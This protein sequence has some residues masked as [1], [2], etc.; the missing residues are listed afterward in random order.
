MNKRV[1][2]VDDDVSTCQLMAEVLAEFGVE[3]IAASTDEDGYRRYLELGPDLIFIDVLLPRKGGIDLLRRIRS[4]RGGRDVPVFVM[5]AVYRGGDIRAQSV[6]ELGALEFLKKPFQ[7]GTLRQRL[8]E[9]LGGGEEEQ[10]VLEPFPPVENLS[11]GNLGVVELP[12]LLKDLALHETSGCLKLRAGKVKKI[13]YLEDGAITFAVSN[14]LR[15]T[16]G[17]HLLQSGKIDDQVYSAGLEAMRTSHRKMGEHLV[18]SG[19]LSAGELADGVRQNVLE[20]VL[21]VFSWP[22]GDFQLVPPAPAP[23]VLPGQPFDALRVLWGGVRGPYSLAKI[24]QALAGYRELYILPQRDLFELASEVPLEKEDLQFLRIVRRLRGQPL[25]Q[26]TAEAQGADE[27]RFLYYLLLRGYLALGRSGGQGRDGRAL[28]VTD[29]D[30]LRRARRRLDALRSR[31]HFQ[32]LGVSLETSDEQ[33][34]AA[35]LQHAKDSHPD[36]LAPADPQELVKIYSEM[37][38]AMQ[39]AYEALKSETRRREYLRFLQDGIEEQPTDGAKILEAE[40]R[41]QAGRQFFKRRDWSQAAEAF[42]EALAL[43][44]DEGEYALDLGLARMRQAGS[45]TSTSLAEAEGLFQRARELMPT[46]PEPPYR[47]G[48]L[49]ARTGDGERAAAFFRAALARDPNHTESLRELRLSKMRNDKAKGSV[50]GGL[51]GRKEQ[52]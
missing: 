49:A 27:I 35:Y 18:E 3:T 47:L 20:K 38:R 14:Q 9:V 22:D 32:V 17:R 25:G 34:R 33:V 51:L 5:S 48:R 12:L 23:A 16:L 52:R 11:R 31:N 15:E 44:P 43:N 10:D 19:A 45:D 29:L 21:E 41:F 30:R 1:L 24:K 4:V 26:I 2:I 42:A 36:M 46:S 50:L 39:A 37:F 7:L 28:D 13:L 8:A 6:D 40:G